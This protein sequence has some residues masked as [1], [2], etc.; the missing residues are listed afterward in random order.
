MGALVTEGSCAHGNPCH[1]RGQGRCKADQGGKTIEA[2][3]EQFTRTAE[4]TYT[5]T[6]ADGSEVTIPVFEFDP[7][8]VALDC[9][10]MIDCLMS[11][12]P[13]GNQIE[14]VGYSFR[15]VIVME[16][17]MDQGR[18]LFHVT[19]GDTNVTSLPP[20]LGVWFRFYGV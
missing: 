1:H 9:I 18:V 10:S 12:D 20:E 6:N 8:L 7:D 11:T 2:R 15:H 5:Y 16:P 19:Q 3:L 4:D 13:C 17:E 14:A